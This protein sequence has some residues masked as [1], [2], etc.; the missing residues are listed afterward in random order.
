MTEYP[1]DV[2][3]DELIHQAEIELGVTFPEELKAIW[4][5][6]NCNELSGGW[7]FYPIFDPSNPRKTAGSIT[8]ENL[9]GAWGKHIRSLGLLALASNGTGNH[10]VARVLDGNVEP[11]IFHWHHETERLTHWKPGISAVMQSAKKS[12]DALAKIRARFKQHKA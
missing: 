10:L 12:V 9:C 8:H 3:N 6:H 5:T 2:A 1:R 4:R 7:R 11:Q